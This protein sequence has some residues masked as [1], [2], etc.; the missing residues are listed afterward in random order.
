MDC[1]YFKIKIFFSYLFIVAI[2]SFQWGQSH[3]QAQTSENESPSPLSN[4]SSQKSFWKNIDTHWGGRFIT[5]GTGSRVTDDTIFAPVGT[6][7]YYD[8]SAN[9]RLINETFFT[10]SLFFEVDYELIWAGGDIIRKQNELK[11]V[12]PNF[13]DDVFFL[14]APLDDDRRLMDLT[15][16]IK[17]ENSWFLLQRLDR[18]Y[19]AL[20][21]TWGS[22][23]VGRQAVTWGNGFVFN[24]M[25]L[26]NPFPPTAIDRDYKVGDDMINAQISLSRLGN[27]QLLYVSR[28]NPDNNKV[29]LDQ[30]SFAGKLHFAVSTTEFDLMG[31][32]HYDDGVAGIGSTGYLGDT[33]WRLD[34]T[35]T[36]LNDG[37]DY[38]SLVANMDYSWVWFDKNLYGFIEYYFNGLGKDNYPDALLDPNITERLARG[39]LFVLGRN[40]VSGH[41][42]IELHPLFQVFFTAIN[43]IEDPSGIL[44]PYATWD[45]AQNLQLTGGLSVSYGVKG[46]EFGGFTL[47]GTDICSKSPDNAYLW[48]IYYF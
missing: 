11:E 16:T 39:E 26:F 47:P 40:F 23:R 38:L 1:L 20:N 37:D 12:F 3:S 41:I 2:I 17:D 8:A 44:Q 35:W 33:A 25:D 14:G 24:P 29:E 7:N 4:Q 19:L 28:R 42:Q 15:H 10:D 6:G 31:A 18:L 32:K 48:L 27:A 34:G 13:S 21:Q 9:L 30:A 43:N 46:T 36:F 45:I 22:V 5:T